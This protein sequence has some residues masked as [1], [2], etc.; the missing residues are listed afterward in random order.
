M[1]PAL[2]ERIATGHRVLNDQWQARSSRLQ[3]RI[4]RLSGLARQ[5][6]EA[7]LFAEMN[8]HERLKTSVARPRFHLDVVGAVFVSPVSFDGE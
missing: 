2:R 1:L 8:R 6:E 4:E 5:S 3:N 7:E